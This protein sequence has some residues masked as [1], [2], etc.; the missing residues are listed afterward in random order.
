MFYSRCLP[1]KRKFSIATVVCLLAQAGLIQAL[2][3]VKHL[4]TTLFMLSFIVNGA[5]DIKLYIELTVE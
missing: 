4:E 1:V 5:I 2:G 3:S